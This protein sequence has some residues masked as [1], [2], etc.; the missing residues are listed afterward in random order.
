MSEVGAAAGHPYAVS[1]GGLGRV[2]YFDLAPTS[3]SRRALCTTALALSL[4]AALP[5]WSRQMSEVDAA[6]RIPYAVSRGSLG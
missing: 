6:P 4:Y 2:S 1:R 5:L 3:Q